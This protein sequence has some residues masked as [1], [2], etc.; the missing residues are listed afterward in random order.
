MNAAEKAFSQY[1]DLCR[2]V[3]GRDDAPGVLE[4]LGRAGMAAL[5]QACHTYR[6]DP[7]ALSGMDDASMFAPDYGVNIFRVN[8][9][10]DVAATFRCGVP[11]LNSLL[12]V[13]AGDVF[14]PTD[15]LLKNMPAGLTVCSLRDVPE[16]LRLQVSEVLERS[17]SKAT[18]AGAAN[19][20]L[21]RDGVLIHAAKGVK[22]D[23]CIQIVNIASASAPALFARRV[24]V[25]AE[26][27]AE[28]R[29]LL[30]DHSQTA[31]Q[32]LNSQVADV[33][34]APGASVEI[35]DIEEGNESTR[36]KWTLN[37]R[38]HEH[39]RLAVGTAYLHG[40]LTQNCYNIDVEGDY[41][42]TSLC[43][44]AICD[45]A[46]QCADN[47]VTLT[48]SARHCTSRQLFKTA[49]FGAARGG[50]G[51]KIIVNEG[52]VF[53]DAEQTNRNIVDGNDAR[54]V[55]APQLEIYC[56]EVKCSH[57]AT[58]GQLDE[59]ALFYMQSRGIPREEARR[60]LTEAFMADVVDCFSFEVLRQ[61]LHALVE[62][63]LSGSHDACDACNTCSH[64]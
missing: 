5:E 29:V 25:I 15:S 7:M 51:G 33:Y 35:Y 8:L 24:V 21:C 64:D 6:P 27:N 61:R 58:T 28:L 49:L 46:G 22:V 54:M 41:A 56:D 10:V 43:G 20:M 17:V 19:A 45:S 2:E 18:P 11:K 30:C 48:H 63:R 60:M 36:R 4:A 31:V 32:H 52:A 13:V 59:R 62:R 26:D 1:I 44:L 53:T 42:D 57:G 38:Q 40:G 9:P 3:Q 14:H 34:V 12:A 50:F 23:K 39:S 37:A 47:K 16:H 55:T